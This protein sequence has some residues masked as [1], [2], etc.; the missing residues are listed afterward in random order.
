MHA[1]E[2]PGLDINPVKEDVFLV[3]QKKTSGPMSCCSG[4][5]VAAKQGRNKNPIAIDVNVEPQFVEALVAAFG[6]VKEYICTFGELNH[7]AHLHAWERSGAVINA[8]K[9]EAQYCVDLKLYSKGFGYSKAMR[10]SAVRKIAEANGFAPCKKTKPYRPGIIFRFDNLVLGTMPLKGHS[11][12]H[13][14]AVLVNE[15]VLFME[16]LAVTNDGATQQS[17]AG[18]CGLPQ[19]SLPK[20]IRD[21]ELVRTVF[22]EHADT[23][24]AGGR[25]SH[26]PDTSEIDRMIEAIHEDNRLVREALNSLSPLP[27]SEKKRVRALLD[28]GLFM[29][30][31]VVADD[32]HVRMREFRAEWAIRHHLRDRIAPSH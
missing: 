7:I 1:P 6:P 4:L 9:S 25:V 14:A 13:V 23:L 32:S 28:R 21:L 29:P 11:P 30:G 22:L 3:N 5:V 27:K 10:F 12:A 16:S 24:V 19:C 2:I 20:L 18:V 31:G 15:R 26:R 8:P 17:M